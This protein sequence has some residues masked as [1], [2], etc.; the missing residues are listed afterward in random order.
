MALTITTSSNGVDYPSGVI[1]DLKYKVIELTFDSSY[2]TGGESLTAS[3]I[4]LD[5][6]VLAQIESTD[7]MSFAYDYTNNKVKAFGTAPIPVQMT[8]LDGAASTGVAVYVHIDTVGTDAD[9]KIAHFES[10]T[11]NNATV[12]F[13]ATS[14]NSA[15]GTMWDDDAANTGGTVLYVDEN[16]DTDLSAAKLLYVSPINEDAY[17]AMSDGSYL[18][19]YDDN[20]AASNGVQLYADDNATNAYEKLMFV[21]PSNASV[22]VHTSTTVSDRADSAEVQAT[23]NLSLQTN[24]RAFI[25]GH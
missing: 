14:T 4:G 8:D 11:A 12:G 2:A 20:S 21:A 9:R 10:I 17:V 7:G 19:I 6:I 16:G 3:D 5:Q 25:L 24:I 23:A 15:T 18:T 22:N 1:G 13:Q